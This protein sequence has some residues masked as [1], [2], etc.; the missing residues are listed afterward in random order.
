MEKPSLIVTLP[1]PAKLRVPAKR[2]RAADDDDDDPDFEPKRRRGITNRRV[3]DSSD[4]D[5]D[6]STSKIGDGSVAQSNNESADTSMT[7][8]DA[9]P[10]A[11]RNAAHDATH[12]ANTHQATPH[13]DPIHQGKSHKIKIKVNYK[14]E[15]DMATIDTTGAT[16][17][18][19]D[20]KVDTVATDGI[21]DVYMGDVAKEDVVAPMD[22]AQGDS[23]HGDGVP[24]TP[25][26]PAH[27]EVAHSD[28][29]S[30]ED[31]S[32]D[33]AS[34]DDNPD[35]DTPDDIE[36][37]SNKNISF[38]N[39]NGDWTH[40]QIKRAH[41]NF[42]QAFPPGPDIFYQPFTSHGLGGF[43]AI[44]HSMAAQ[45]PDL[46][47]P[48]LTELAFALKRCSKVTLKTRLIQPCKTVFDV[49]SASKLDGQ[50]NWEPDCFNNDTRILLQ[51]HLA[52]IFYLWQKGRGVDITLAI[53]NNGAPWAWAYKLWER[54]GFRVS[55][56]RVVW[57]YHDGHCSYAG[58]GPIGSRGA[59]K[60]LQ[61]KEDEL[62]AYWHI[63]QGAGSLTAGSRTAR[64]YVA[65]EAQQSTLAET[66]TPAEQL[67]PDEQ[68]KAL[69]DAEG[70]PAPAEEGS[71]PV[72]KESAPVEKESAPV[73]KESA[74]AAQTG[75]VEQSVPHIQ[76]GPIEEQSVTAQDTPVSGAEDTA[77]AE[78][79]SPIENTVPADK[80]S[81][82]VQASPAAETA[83]PVEPLVTGKELVSGEQLVPAGGETIPAEACPVEQSSH[84]EISVPDMQSAIAQKQP[85]GA[86]DI[87]LADQPAPVEN[88]VTADQLPPRCNR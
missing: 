7:T 1:L 30:E 41:T 55:T 87:A 36:D 51:D 16:S 61:F 56:D 59:I 9:S 67:V 84:T 33:D 40:K 74:S 71:D 58:L 17:T 39:D 47:V 70:K 76:S 35:D 29:A 42:K 53:W 34:D 68:L 62:H 10:E 46:R 28:M 26:A 73:E 18:P 6:A 66:S 4:E 86:A 44:I 72:E 50:G 49:L 15:S 57:I 20:N 13:E 43:Q 37:K 65:L 88:A 85:A 32:S 38:I 81:S 12:D 2:K 60:G 8:N 5:S 25:A 14:S 83:V 82:E 19:V 31:A 27:Q 21:Q 63:V 69:K 75:L 52:L 45:H 3:V 80:T 22:T 77:P 79:P 48:K 54:D 64:D 23:A 11:T 78:Q 24:E